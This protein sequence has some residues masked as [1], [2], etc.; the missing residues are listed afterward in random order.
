MA[1]SKFMIAVAAHTGQM[2]NYSN[3]ADEIGKDQT[4]VK[5]WISILEASGIIYLLDPY[6]ASVLKRAI[7][8]PKI[9]LEIPD[10]SL[11][12]LVGLHP[13]HSL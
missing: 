2:L 5:K 7:K 4:T 13:K 12:Q 11:T 1:T 6:T 8:T 3:I 9:S 10:L